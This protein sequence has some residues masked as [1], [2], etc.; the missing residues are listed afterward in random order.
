MRDQLSARSVTDEASGVRWVPFLLVCLAY[1]ATTTGEAV[2]SPVYPVAADELG[3]DLQQAGIAFALLAVAIAVFNIVGGLLLRRLPTPAV[4]SVALATSGAGAMAAAT[5]S[6]GTQFIIAQLFLGAGAGLLYPGAILSVGSLGGSRR[7]FA[8]GIFGIFFSGGLVLA[9]GLAAL[10]SRLHWRWPFAI[11]AMLALIASVS[12]WFIT[13][14]PRANRSGPMF[15]GLR[16]VLGVPTIVGVVGGISQ[17]A[18]V[19]FLPV[20]AVDVWGLREAT[21]AGILA[22]GRVLSVPAKLV[23]GS[24]ADRISPV[25]TA[26]IIGVVL[27]ASGLVWALAPVRWIAAVAAIVF[28]AEVSALFPL[29]NLLAFERV[30]RAGPALGAFRSL[31]LGAGAAAG[32]AVGAAAHAFG[33]RVTVAVVASVP[34][35]LLFLRAARPE[36][37]DSDEVFRSG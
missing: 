29:A 19:S 32:L 21:A 23:S 24:M 5:A 36:S 6:G 35:G 37:A 14:A 17:Y 7:G 25:A 34:L 4:L 3:L 33:L 1:L 18:T 26:K 9:A 2:L 27:T 13:D 31:Q 30:G 22:V 8:M 15:A 12:V 10:G 16:A 28:A 20:F 11:A